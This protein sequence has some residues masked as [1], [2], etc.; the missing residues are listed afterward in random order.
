MVAVNGIPQAYTPSDLGKRVRE[1]ER[2]MQELTSARNLRNASV[3]GPL[4]VTG[5]GSLNVE[6]DF[7][8][9]AGS[10]S[11][12]SLQAPVEDG[13]AS[14]AVSNI[15][16]T[17]TSTNTVIVTLTVPDGFTKA[18]IVAQGAANVANTGTT[19]DKVTA[20]CWI[21]ATSGQPLYSQVAAGGSTALTTMVQREVTG[22]ASG[23]IIVCTLEL[24][25]DAT[26]FPADPGTTASLNAFAIF[27]R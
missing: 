3:D 15:E 5:T 6:G 1:L 17:P 27:R 7:N 11:N 14:A 25:T 19:A 9:P 22:L 24:H 10:I 20:L 8:V 21:D 16:I 18:L 26:T 23:Q 12:E 2:K 4:T 13:S